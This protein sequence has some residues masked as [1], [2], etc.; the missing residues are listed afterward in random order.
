VEFA[1]FERFSANQGNVP[2]AKSFEKVI[3]FFAG[4]FI[5][6]VPFDTSLLLLNR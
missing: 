6:H 2:V 1:E 5:F 4:E 3:A